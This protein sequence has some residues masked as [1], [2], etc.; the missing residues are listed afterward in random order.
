MAIKDGT[1]TYINDHH[2]VRALVNYAPSDKMEY[3]P[4]DIAPKKFGDF[5][6]SSRYSMSSL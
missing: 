4:E 1:S 6:E 2:D 5:M 3:G